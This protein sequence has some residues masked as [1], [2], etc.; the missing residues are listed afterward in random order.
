MFHSDICHLNEIFE[1]KQIHVESIQS[2]NSGETYKRNN[3][4]TWKYHNIY[5]PSREEVGLCLSGK[6][7]E[8]MVPSKI[9]QTV[10]HENDWI[11]DHLKRETHTIGRQHRNAIIKEI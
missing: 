1:N 3:Q 5:G 2:K 4:K 11:L 9:L 6:E 10:K 7:S 8:E